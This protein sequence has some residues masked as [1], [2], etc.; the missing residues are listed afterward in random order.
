[1]WPGES[2]RSGWKA[3]AGLWSLGH[4]SL[5]CSLDRLPLG[6][7][8]HETEEVKVCAV[9]GLLLRCEAG[10]WCHG[11]LFGYL[12]YRHQPPGSPEGSRVFT[13]WVGWPR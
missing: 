5:S 2:R 6:E 12:K 11:V 9:D 7:T 13:R 8:V 10:G 3:P 4:G 1:M